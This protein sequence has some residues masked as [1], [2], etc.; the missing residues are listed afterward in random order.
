MWKKIK[1]QLK[2]AR[3]VLEYILTV[4]LFFVIKK[5]S[6]RRSSDLCGFIGKYLGRAIC[7][8]NGKTKIALK[9]MALCLPDKTP[10]EHTKILNM[11]LD[12]MGRF[13]GE[14]LHQRSMDDEYVT[15]NVEVEGAEYFSDLYKNGKGFFGFTAHFGNWELIHRHLAKDNIMLNVIYRKQNNKLIEQKYIDQRPVNQIPKGS[16]S[17]R[18]II[19]LIKA[20]KVIG[21]L[22]DQRD[23]NGI[24]LEFFGKKAMTSTAIQ[25]LSLKYDFPII[26]VKCVRKKDDRNKFKMTVYPPL[27]LEKSGNFETDVIEL[28]KKTLRIIEEWIKEDPEQWMWV[29]DRWKGVPAQQ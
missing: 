6:I 18:D 16:R 8:F 9:S 20:N 7:F 12:G 28:T 13:M 10:D 17:M 21:V 2:K 29:Y 14:Y 26:P 19:D 27:V 15:N 5:M 22:L 1:K 3:Y 24:P 4:V 11:V 23:L 25:R